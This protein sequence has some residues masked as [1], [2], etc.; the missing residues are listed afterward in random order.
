[1][2]EPTLLVG[3]I[4]TG[5]L[6]LL[7]KTLSEKGYK[8]LSA[9]PGTALVAEVAQQAPDLLV[10]DIH[11]LGVCAEIRRQWQHLPILLLGSTYDEQLAIR[12]LDQ[13]A[14]DY[15]AQPFALDEVAARIRT[16]IRRAEGI[17]PGA[18][19]PAIFRSEDGYLCMN[20]TSH[21][22][23]VGGGNIQLTRTEFAL[24]Q[25]LMKHSE[26]V[27]THRYLLHRVWGSEYGEENNYVRVYIYQLRRK[28]EKDPACPRYIRTEPGVGYVFR[29]SPPQEE[30]WKDSM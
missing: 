27:L 28:V 1:M 10:L 5:G 26:K 6:R 15:V 7:K 8:V 29:S 23:V 22:V 20:I 11:D 2:K 13:G 3:E 9:T 17:K 25:E 12:A 14:D 4:D 24:L 19:E 16:L 21:E 18:P 30:R